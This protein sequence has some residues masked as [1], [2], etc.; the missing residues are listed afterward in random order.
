MLAPLDIYA[1]NS[2]RAPSEEVIFLI[3]EAIDIGGVLARKVE[4]V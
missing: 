3:P 1:F 2:V 4:K